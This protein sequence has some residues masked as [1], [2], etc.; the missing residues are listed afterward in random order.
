MFENNIIAAIIP[1]RGRS[2][3]IPKKNIKKLGGKPLIAYT[4][5]EALKSKYIDRVIVSTDDKEIAAIAKKSGA[6]VP[7]LRPKELA[8]DTSSSLSVVLHALNYLEKEENYHPGIIVFLQPTSPFR[9]AKHIDNGIEK[10]KDC[11]AV[12]GV[13]EV[14]QHPY[15]MMLKKGEFLEPYLKIK[16]RPLRRQ[17][18]PSLYVLNASLYIAKRDY[19]NHVVD[20][21]PV[22]PIFR[23][24]VKGVFMDEIISSVDI[25]TQLDFMIAETILKK[26]KKMKRAK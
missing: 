7:F 13:C 12:V 15:F 21:E 10:I 25:N 14:K 23:G 18:T 16:N 19:F 6:E 9:T 2:K 20:T 4:I 22:A 26:L 24:K 1:A 3:T 17:D 8:K 11:D 5:E